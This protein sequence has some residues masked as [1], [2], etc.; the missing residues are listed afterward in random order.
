MVFMAKEY[1]TPIPSSKRR[2]SAATDF[3]HRNGDRMVSCPV[4]LAPLTAYTR[5]LML[6][7]IRTALRHDHRDV[8]L[9]F[10]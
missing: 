1:L 6:S 4:L 3:Y 7:H 5:R 2:G 8:I 9:L 10:Q